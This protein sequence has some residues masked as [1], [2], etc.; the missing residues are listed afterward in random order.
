MACRVRQKRYSDVRHAGRRWRAVA[1][2]V[3]CS[4]FITFHTMAAAGIVFPATKAKAVGPP[5]PVTTGNN[6]ALHRS[7]QTVRLAAD[8]SGVID[9]R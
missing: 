6:A 8:T 7:D 3:A 5:G 9:F 1:L 2:A 4:T